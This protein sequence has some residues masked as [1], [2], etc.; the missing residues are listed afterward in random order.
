MLAAA[1]LWLAPVAMATSIEF[2]GLF[3]GQTSKRNVGKGVHVQGEGIINFAKWIPVTGTSYG[4]GDAAMGGYWG[5]R[6]LDANAAVQ[7]NYAEGSYEFVAGSSFTGLNYDL[8]M[9]IAGPWDLSDISKKDPNRDRAPRYP[10]FSAKLRIDSITIPEDD[11]I[12]ITGTLVDAVNN[13]A[14]SA[15]LTDLANSTGLSFTLNL[16]GSGRSK[17]SL[18]KA[19][20]VGKK[21]AWAD[22]SGELASGGGGGVPEPGTLL[23]LGSALAGGAGW[24][25]L[26]RRKKKAAQKQAKS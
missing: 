25:R 6:S 4:D 8:D 9:W 3:A 14:A 19:L 11:A 26:R 21:S 18:S 7:T 2:A 5:A 10:W 15:A 22:L 23:L 17:S 16:V 13:Y 12:V 20:R 24:G 1:V